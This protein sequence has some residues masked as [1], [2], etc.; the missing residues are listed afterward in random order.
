MKIPI[1]KV[2]LLYS[3][4]VRLKKLSEE[5]VYETELLSGALL[6]ESLLE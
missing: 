3:G 5:L 2:S 1:E 4:Q 6:T